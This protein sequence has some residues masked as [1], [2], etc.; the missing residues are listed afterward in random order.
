MDTPSLDLSI[1][2]FGD[3]LLF[4][5][6]YLATF[7]TPL[8]RSVD[9]CN[10]SLSTKKPCTFAHEIHVIAIYFD[11]HTFLPDN[12]CC[13]DTLGTNLISTTNIHANYHFP[14]RAPWN[15]IPEFSPWYVCL[16]EQMADLLNSNRREP[17]SNSLSTGKW[18][19]CMTV[20]FVG[21]AGFQ[22][23]KTFFSFLLMHLPRFIHIWSTFLSLRL[24]YLSCSLNWLNPQC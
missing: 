2:R 17:I 10:Y 24:V 11:A 8:Y 6:F 13:T 1:Y 20:P 15:P 5:R 22:F 9:F 7:C 12:R 18:L 23:F 21:S 3:F 4:F 14:L 19:K 16:R